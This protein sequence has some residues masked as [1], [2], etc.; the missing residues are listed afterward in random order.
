[1]GM[2]LIND[3]IDDMSEFDAGEILNIL[4]TRMIQSLHQKNNNSENYDGMDIGLCIW[5]KDTN[6][7]NFSGAYNPL[8]LVR[9]DKLIE[10]K[11]TRMSIGIRSRLDESYKSHH[12]Q[13]QKDDVFYL[14]TDGYPDQ[15]SLETGKKM[16]RQKF[17]ELIVHINREDLLKQKAE[18]ADYFDKWKGGY[19]QID[20][21]LVMGVRV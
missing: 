12:I 11:S 2:F 17:K 4:R 19:E 9:D 13:L 15:L 8:Y 14:F 1:L 10:Y 16:T 7:L 6:M 21:V 5:D 3:I 18:V 20:D